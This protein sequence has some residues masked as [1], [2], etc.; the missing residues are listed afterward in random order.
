MDNLKTHA[1]N[2]IEC[3]SLLNSVMI[4]SCHIG[5]KFK[6]HKCDAILVVKRR[7]N[8]EITDDMVMADGSVTETIRLWIAD[9]LEFWNAKRVRS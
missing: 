9:T 6:L 2:R 4:F 3:E 5:I 8:E 7:K 1:K